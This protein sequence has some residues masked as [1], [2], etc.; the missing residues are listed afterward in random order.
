MAKS[1][2]QDERKCIVTGCTEGLD[3]HHI[4]FGPLRQVSERM[5]FKVWLRHDVHMML[6]ARQKPFQNLDRELKRAC[7]EA[8]EAMGHTRREFMAIIGR[9]YLD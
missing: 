5:G 3:C 1:I 8:F 7:Q 4:Y 6:H 9:N 2:L